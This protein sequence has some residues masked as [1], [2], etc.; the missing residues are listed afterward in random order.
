MTS[1][2]HF[3]WYILGICVFGIL[4][5]CIVCHNIA[6]I[7]C[8]ICW[9][10][11]VWHSITTYCIA[12]Q[13]CNI[14]IDTYLTLVWTPCLMHRCVCIWRY[15]CLMHRYV[16]STMFGSCFSFFK[17]LFIFFIIYYYA[18]SVFIIILYSKNKVFLF[19]F[20]I[21]VYLD[22]SL[23]FGERRHTSFFFK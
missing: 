8:N 21:F 17:K 12:W 1:M 13:V 16:I 6:T 2:W 5:I 22:A 11:I 23:K 18:F 14:L 19:H 10:A 15:L 20:C 9:Y 7:F 3:D 4:L